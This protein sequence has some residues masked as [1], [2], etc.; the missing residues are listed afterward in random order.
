MAALT[1]QIL[2]GTPHQNHGGINP[3]HY[4]FLSENNRPAWILV[5]ENVFNEEP[6]KFNKITW[7]PTLENMLE[8]ALLMIA[9]HV[10]KDKELC[11]LSKKYFRKK[12]SEW[13]E[14]YEDI[15]MKDLKKLYKKCSEI[16]NRH[17]VVISVFEGS[18]IRSNHMKTLENYR[19]D[20]EVCTP[21]YLRIYSPWNGKTRIEGSLSSRES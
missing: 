3:T 7:V 9:I 18:S 21:T 11:D 14:L 19:M 8:D 6:G 13:A 20:V 4:L 2:V 10:I 1:A 16:G 12:A 17:K 5:P 15:D